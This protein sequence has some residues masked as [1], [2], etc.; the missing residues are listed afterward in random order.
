MKTTTINLN[1]YFQQF[2]KNVIG[3]EEAFTT[4][5]GKKKMIYADWTASGRLYFPIERA[6][7]KILARLSEIH[8]QKLMLL[9]HQ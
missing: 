8:I 5:N 6:L 3:V 2:R 4:P 1:Q 7:L 9:V